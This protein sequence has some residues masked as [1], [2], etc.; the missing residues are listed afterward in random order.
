VIVSD[1]NLVVSTFWRSSSKTSPDLH[2]GEI[3][4]VGYHANGVVPCVEFSTGQGKLCGL[5]VGLNV[6]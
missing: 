2:A 6:R 5:D 3:N 1:S 4:Q